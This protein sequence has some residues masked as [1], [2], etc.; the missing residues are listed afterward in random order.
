M[1]TTPIV[2][3]TDWAASQASPWVPHNEAV[4]RLEANGRRAIIVDRDLT[5][6][7]GSCTDGA[8]YIVASSGTGL[9]ASQTGKMATAVG[10]N[11]ANGWLFTTVAVE[12]FEIYV[13]DENAFLYYTGAAWDPRL[14]TE[15]SAS[16]IWAASSTTTFV[17]PSKA[18]AAGVPA[19]LTSSSSI[20]PN[21]ANGLNFSL[22]L[23][24]NATLENPTNFGIGRSG[25]IVITQDTG[26]GFTL[27]YGS[28]WKFPGGSPVLSTGAGEVDL[29]AYFVAASGVIL[30]TLTKAYSA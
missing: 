7:P 23:G 28:D 2:G 10:T 26:G 19:A 8:C 6:P 17:S 24:H 21:G 11:A 4:R 25:L 9:W 12:G 29:L 1:T 22:T 5:A 30:A 16:N 3:A 15:A 20:T 14:P 27:A 13:Q 18:L